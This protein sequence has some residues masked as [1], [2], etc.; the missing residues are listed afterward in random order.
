MEEK[1]EKA[2]MICLEML[3]QRGYTDAYE[4][5][6]LNNNP[7]VVLVNPETNDK[8][9]IHF[10]RTFK[11]NTEQLEV[12]LTITKNIGLNHCIILYSNSIT[13]KAKSIIDKKNMI[14]EDLSIKCELFTF[15][16]L[17]YN[18]TKHSFVPTH[19]RLS[20]IQAKTFKIKYGVK[21]PILLTSDP[22]S[23][24]FGYETGDVIRI[25]RSSG[26]IAYRIV[27]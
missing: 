14:S 7:F 15:A 11:L 13:P 12:F 6:D 10:S 21:H 5:I 18:I 24:F 2:I 1:I 3:E 8:I 4:H 16:E 20:K 25:E 22:V 9:C 23:R 17:Q 27:K 19:K 26:L